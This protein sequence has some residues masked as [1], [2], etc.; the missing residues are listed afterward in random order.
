MVAI[1]RFFGGYGSGSRHGFVFGVGIDMTSGNVYDKDSPKD[2]DHV[3]YSPYMSR[4]RFRG[5]MDYFKDVRQGLTDG[6]A[7]VGFHF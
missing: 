4:H 3:F 5:Y 1:S 6:I 2:P 7:R